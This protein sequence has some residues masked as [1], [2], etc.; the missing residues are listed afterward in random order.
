M[1]ERLANDVNAKL[2]EDFHLFMKKN[3]CLES[4]RNNTLKTS[5]AFANFLCPEESLY[6]LGTKDK[7]TAFLDTKIKD[8]QDDPDR[9]CITT[10]NDYVGDLK[11]LFRWLH[12]YKVKEEQGLE[13]S[14]NPSEWI[15]PELS[16]FN[17]EDL[18]N[19][20]HMCLYVEIQYLVIVTK[21][22]SESFLA[23][24]THNTNSII[25]IF[26]RYTSGLQT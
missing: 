11:Y 9:R 17:E 25:G 20:V 19:N 13:P 6:E 18:G 14:P 3:D 2:L 21:V 5:I 24:A 22:T 4:H 1:K 15:T 10:W 26:I 16:Y 12:N 23:I 7:I 8:A